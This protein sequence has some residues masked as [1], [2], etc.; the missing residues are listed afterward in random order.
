MRE[1]EREREI[2]FAPIDRIF[3]GFLESLELVPMHVHST[4][5]VSNLHED[6]D[7]RSNVFEFEGKEDI[8]YVQVA[9]QYIWLK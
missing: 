8:W 5:L 4:F 9:K 1:R 3:L 2:S 7:I 6:H